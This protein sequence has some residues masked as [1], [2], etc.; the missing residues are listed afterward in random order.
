MAT[1]DITARI[2][3]ATLAAEGLITVKIYREDPAIYFSQALGDPVT[4]VRANFPNQTVNV[5]GSTILRLMDIPTLRDA[6]DGAGFYVAMRGALA[7]WGAAS[8]WQ[9]DD[10]TADFQQ[11][12]TVDQA[13]PIGF[14]K[15]VLPAG[16]INTLDYANTLEIEL[17]GGTLESM[18]LEEMLKGEV[19]YLIGDEIV[20]SQNVSQLSATRWS[21]DGPMVRG[22]KGTEWAMATHL[23]NERAILLRQAITFRINDALAVIS[24]P[25]QFKAVSS[26][27]DITG[28]Q[29]TTFTDTG[30]SLKPWAPVD[31]RGLAD[32]GDDVQIT[33]KRRSRLQG[34]NGRDFYDPPLAETAESYELDILEDDESAV[35][36]TLTST[37]EAFTYNDADQTTD[38]GGLK[39]TNLHINIYQISAEVGR[40]YPGHAIINPSGAADFGAFEM[41]FQDGNVIE[42]ED[43]A[44]MQFEQ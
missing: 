28:A 37:T 8:L 24:Q 17:I 39:G 26:G 38:F 2:A 18:S 10:D 5:P 35:L 7:T 4:A 33:F 32:I 34:R 12:K 31:I 30:I 27:M 19:A 6:D 13:S 11:V 25:R 36:R 40:G 1:R 42:F 15:E 20:L 29:A 43:G 9:S 16:E 14:A 22:Y 21:L 3:E 44:A 41:L 23:L